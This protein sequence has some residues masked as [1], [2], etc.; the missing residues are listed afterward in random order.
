MAEDKINLNRLQHKTIGKT[1]SIDEK[2]TIEY[3]EKVGKV[4]FI[5]GLNGSMDEIRLLVNKVYQDLNEFRYG[6]YV[7]GID[8]GYKRTQW[9]ASLGIINAN[10]ATTNA[11]KHLNVIQTN[12][13]DKFI[14]N[15]KGEISAVTANLNTHTHDYE[16]E[17]HSFSVDDLAVVDLATNYRKYGIITKKDWCPND[18][19]FDMPDEVYDMI[20][21]INRGWQHFEASKREW[22]LFNLYRMQAHRWMM[23]KG[24]MNESW[25]L[26]K[27]KEWLKDERE[28]CLENSLYLANKYLW[29]KDPD[30]YVTGE[31]KFKAWKAQEIV[32]FLMDSGYSLIIGK[33]RQIG[34][35]TVI[36]GI[37]A[38]RTMIS[39]NFYVKMVAQKGDKSEEIFES[40]IKYPISKCDNILKPTIPNWSTDLV[41]F[42][43]S[44]GKGKESSTE[45]IFEV[46]A[47]T[48]DAINAGTPKI[49][50]LDEIG[51]MK[52]FGAII[53]QG[54]PTMFKLD[55]ATGKMR[56]TK[57]VIAWGTG[58]KTGGAG[59]AMEV[60]WKA[61]KEAFAQ[62]NFRHGLIPLFLNFYAKPGHTDEFYMQEK[63]FYYAKKK[64]AGE[65]DP[66]IVFHQSFPITEDDMFL[67]SSETVISVA[68]INLNIERIGRDMV[69]GR[70]KPIR[71]Y[72]EPL[73]N[74]DKPRGE[75]SYTPYEIIGA[76]FIPADE[77]LIEEDS[78][79]ACVTLFKRPEKGWL[80]RYYKGTDP[81]FTSSGHSKFASVVR[82]ALDKDI[83]AAL[84]FKS[85]DY[86]FEY[87]QSLLL[88]LFY[89]PEYGGRAVGIKELLEFNVGGEYYNMC[90]ELGYGGIFTGNKMLPSNLQTTTIDIGIN[91]RGTNSIILVNR[92]EEML[93]DESSKIN[94][95]DF[96]IQLKTFVR[97]QTL[98][99][100]KYEPEN[101]KIHYDDVIDAAVYSKINADIHAHLPIKQVTAQ[102][103]QVKA[104]KKLRYYYDSNFNLRLGTA[105]QASRRA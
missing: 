76:R 56:M 58:G 61:A 63:A 96:W 24:T 99:G 60:E 105:A 21:L 1:K 10:I 93:M 28:K 8:I 25:T 79:F 49:T 20:I 67:Q 41:K 6:L 59:G 29:C 15:N 78:P 46:T 77:T 83:A 62:R 69:G 57:Q 43:Y 11:K 97:K 31:F 12:Y 80:N 54:R 66:K 103:M 45:S 16:Y 102:E 64:K 9:L 52:F 70:I 75:D 81:I 34:F 23:E 35:T 14:V 18:N 94:L 44:S 95:L 104:S 98:T 92:L 85:E 33:L 87:R 27:K 71:G 17:D 13:V 72:F 53:S 39:K 47:P 74:T 82:D 2:G 73:F 4:E 3:I 55:P 84:N 22:K 51:F 48:E 40:K 7:A 36:G 89:S 91:K 86:R 88:N 38:L 101:K 68:A 26:D 90:R 100:Y 30:N 19:I 65:E 42:G 50:L 37:T 5:T 32:L